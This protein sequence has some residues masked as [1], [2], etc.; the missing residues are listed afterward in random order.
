[1]E[2]PG[3]ET[4]SLCIQASLEGD[5]RAYARLIE[6]YAPCVTAQMR[7]FTRNPQALDELVQEVFVEVYFSLSGF[8]GRAPFLHWVRRIATR[9]GYRYWNEQAR[10]RRRKAA[11]AAHGDTLRP[12]S[13][14]P[15]PSE[16]AEHLYHLLEQLPPK[17]RLVL[18][19]YYF[20]D[21]DTQDIAERTGWSRTLVKVRAHRARRKLRALLEDGGYTSGRNGNA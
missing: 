21:C 10:D 8:E 12:L 2:R 5:E 15:A 3:A 11:L 19:L 14:S 1:M 4:D 17:D 6:R 13:D 9:V 7:R 18:T 16:A 20:D